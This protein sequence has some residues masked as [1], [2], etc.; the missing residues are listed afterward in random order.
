MADAASAASEVGSSVVVAQTSLARDNKAYNVSSRRVSSAV[1]HCC[2]ELAVRP[3]KEPAQ[4][5]LS[6]N[7][8]ETITYLESTMG[9]NFQRFEFLYI[10]TTYFCLDAREKSIQNAACWLAWIFSA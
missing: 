2:K 3:Y 1:M 8:V 4:P 7:L 5:Q 6:F 9:V 10:C